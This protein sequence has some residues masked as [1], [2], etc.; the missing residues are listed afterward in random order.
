ME[1]S[2]IYTVL[3]FHNF[4]EASSLF[5]SECVPDYP[6]SRVE[7]DQDVIVGIGVGLGIERFNDGDQQK[8]RENDRNSEDSE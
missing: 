1:I 5:G 3:L 7:T 4:P 8:V 2:L 6:I